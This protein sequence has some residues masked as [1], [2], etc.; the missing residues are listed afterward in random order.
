MKILA[1]VPYP[2]LGALIHEAAERYP[3]M[4]V[5]TFVGYYGNAMA[6]LT[7]FPRDRFDIII[8]RGGTTTLLMEKVKI[9]VIDIRLSPVDIVRVLLQTQQLQLKTA[10]ITYPDIAELFTSLADSLHINISVYSFNTP[11]RIESLV[12]RCRKDGCRVVI[13]GAMARDICLAHGLQFFLIASGREAIEECL[14]LAHRTYEAGRLLSERADLFEHLTDLNDAPTILYDSSGSLRFANTAAWT[15]FGREENS[16]KRIEEILPMLEKEGELHLVQK[17]GSYYYKMNGHRFTI[18]GKTYSS[19]D[20]HFRSPDYRPTSF[21]RIKTPFEVE[22]AIAAC[23]YASLLALP[24]TGDLKASASSGMTI[25]IRGEVG[26][27]KDLFAHIVHREVNGSA[28]FIQISCRNVS[29]KGWLTLLRKSASPLYGTSY[30][31]FFEDIDMLSLPMQA[32]LVSYMT[33]TKLAVRH[34]IISCAHTDLSELVASGSFSEELYL[35]LS[36]Y[37]ITMYPL[38][39]RRA[40][41]PA[42]LQQIL[43]VYNDQFSRFV[44]GFTKEA[45]ALLTSF[46]WPLNFTQM[47][48][49]VRQ[50]VSQTDGSYVS[51]DAVRSAL[52]NAPDFA[53]LSTFDL[54]GTLDEIEK[55]II[56][57]ILKE[58]NMNQ[59]AAA[60]RLGIGRSTLWRK[61]NGH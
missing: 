45:L 48:T 5:T 34:R 61:L 27:R 10:V 37:T 19:F 42:F 31:I 50:L 46:N 22:S 26:T 52:R 3:D 21:T 30:S 15:L 16:M 55:R 13:G 14:A 32:E 39:E 29:E 41:I 60:K 23:P 1:I 36:G 54:S 8:S 17:I 20:L 38:S 25:H 58:E 24:Y 59:S 11:D 33:D 40:D 35:L 4:D 44:I 7:T 43:P 6:Y 9:P 57:R 53:T 2:E 49:M 47:E 18:D 28:S 51:A 12:E 56:A